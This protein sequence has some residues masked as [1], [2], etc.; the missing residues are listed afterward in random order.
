VFNL[1]SAAAG[2]LAWQTVVNQAMPP[3]H[4]RFRF[5]LSAYSVGL[6]GNVLL[7]G[8]AGEIVRV[9]VLARKLPGRQGVWATLVGTVVAY[10]L[11]DLVPSVLLL[12]YVLLFAPLPHWAITS[13]VLVLAAGPVLRVVGFVTARRH[14]LPA[15]KAPGPVRELIVMARQGLGVLRAPLPAVRG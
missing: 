11:L 13:L 2:S 6:L 5:I 9:A 15:A 14:E 8:R 4:P 12:T 10:R 7:P 3:P 1:V